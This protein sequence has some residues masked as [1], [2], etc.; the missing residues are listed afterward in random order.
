MILLF[1]NKKIRLTAFISIPIALLFYF[2]L[3]YFIDRSAGSS[4]GESVNNAIETVNSISISA[5][6]LTSFKGLGDLFSV[7]GFFN[8]V[9]FSGLFYRSFRK[10]IAPWFNKLFIVFLLTIILHMLLSTEL[11]R[12]FYLGS[13]LF[14]PLLAR[15]FEINPLF[16]KF[17]Y[18]QVN[19]LPPGE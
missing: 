14:V 10:K 8:L 9:F 5:I 15:S 13:A 6:K 4:A 1:A 12:M 3:K 7:Y 2:F 16:K 17:Q 18:K 11:A 19:N